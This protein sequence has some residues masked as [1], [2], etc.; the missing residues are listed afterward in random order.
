M[1][2]IL[3]IAIAI[4]FST[5]TVA[6]ESNW[7]HKP[8]YCG[9]IPEV[10]KEIIDKHDLHP[11]MAAVGHVKSTL[12]PADLLSPT[13][14]YINSETKR[15]VLV[16]FGHGEGACITSIGNGIDFDVT[17]EQVKELLRLEPEKMTM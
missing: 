10:Y 5:T 4:A 14:L 12:A 9:S 16:E 11:I 8:V 2:R 3:V 13:V 15:Y 17:A 6:Q 7:R 1:L